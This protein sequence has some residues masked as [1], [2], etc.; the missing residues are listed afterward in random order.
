MYHQYKYR[1]EP[2]FLRISPALPTI[3]PRQHHDC[4]TDF[5]QIPGTDHLLSRYTTTPDLSEEGLSWSGSY[6][7]MKHKRHH[8][9]A[10]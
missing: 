10:E 6:P 9:Q 8:I 5:L 2:C 1:K 3:L 4:R 7:Y